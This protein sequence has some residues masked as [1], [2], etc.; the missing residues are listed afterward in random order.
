MALRAQIQRSLACLTAGSLL[1]CAHAPVAARPLATPVMAAADAARPHL[2][3]TADAAGWHG[4][5]LPTMDV[6]SVPVA[7]WISPFAASDA[8]DFVDSHEGAWRANLGA[9]SVP[10]RAQAATALG[11]LADR[12]LGAAALMR[13]ALKGQLLASATR[14]GG[15]TLL[16]SVGS[17]SKEPL[18]RGLGR[19]ELLEQTLAELDVPG[20]VTQGLKYTCESA[21]AQILLAERDPA[22]YTRLIAGLAS[23]SGTVAL[24]DGSSIGRVADWASNSDGWRSLSSRL[25]QPAFAT[26]GNAPL[27]YSN[28]KDLNSVGVS[29]LTEAQ[30]AKLLS[31]L[32]G[33][34]FACLSPA[35]SSRQRRMEAYLAAIAA[36]WHVPVWVEWSTGHVV[37][38]EPEKRGRVVIDNPYGVMHSLTPGAFMSVL[39]SVYLPAIVA[40]P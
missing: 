33:T 15:P 27:S 9:M 32:F 39:H 38:A 1:A 29:G 5:W 14:R 28:T 40:I 35:N 20:R 30:M 13:L 24:A 2:S 23:E 11:L 6:L 21:S 4:V 26:F 10:D 12:P 36:G 37:L 8:Q 19:A 18:A 7:D 34:P 3:G 16:A 25:L 22:E 17:L 31:A